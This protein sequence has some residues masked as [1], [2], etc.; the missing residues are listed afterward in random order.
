MSDSLIYSERFVALQPVGVFS[1]VSALVTTAVELTRFH[2]G[3]LLIR[4]ACFLSLCHL[5]NTV[6]WCDRAHTHWIIQSFLKSTAAPGGFQSCVPGTKCYWH[7]VVCSFSGL[8]RR[9]QT[10]WTTSTASCCST[11]TRCWEK[12]VCTRRP[13][14]ICP[15]TRSRSAINWQWRRRE[16]G[17]CWV[18]LLIFGSANIFTKVTPN[19]QNFIERAHFIHSG[20]MVLMVW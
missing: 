19:K 11:R 17:D 6:S 5:C 14:S 4:P 10:K 18:S 15:T 20:G 12:Q 7:S 8:F 16:V 1:V 2:S 13:S 3:V 9:L